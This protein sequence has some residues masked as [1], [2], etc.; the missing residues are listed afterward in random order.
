MFWSSTG[1]AFVIIALL[2]L[3]RLIEVVYS[4]SNTRALKA[5]GAVEIGRNHYPVMVS[6]HVA[7]FIAIVAMLP[8]P[9]P[10]YTIPILATIVLQGLRGW[11]LL[12]L[13]PYWTTRIINLPGAPVVK[14]GPYRFVRHPNYAVVAAEIFVFP[15]AFGEVW[16]AA[17]FTVLNAAMLYWRIR[18]EDA[19][20][21][22]RRVLTEAS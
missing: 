10:I 15:L 19:A 2:G 20:L 21:A 6:L 18:E 22:P 5:R 12:T 13:G 14:R 16:V 7:W 1:A 17:V 3:Q 11:V 4:E 9:T 8:Y